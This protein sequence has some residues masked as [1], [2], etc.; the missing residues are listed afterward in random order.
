MSRMILDDLNSY[1]VAFWQANQSTL[2]QGPPFNIADT[3]TNIGN[4][5]NALNGDTDISQII[6]TDNTAISLNV[7]RLTS[8]AT[9]ISKLVNQDSSPVQLTVNDTAAHIGNG[10]A[11]IGTNPLVTVVK[12]SD[13]S[14]VTVTASQF[15]SNL[16]VV[17]EL[18]N[19]N[20]TAAQIIVKDTAV[21]IASALD[22]IETYVVHITTASAFVS[23]IV[24]S[25]SFALTLTAAQVANDGDALAIV[26]NNNG[27]PV[28]FKVADTAANITS[29]LDALQANGQIT[30]ITDTD[31][32]AITV[33]VAQITADATALG[34][35]V[36]A[37][38][39]P[40]T[41]IVNDTAAH[42]QAA[43]NGLSGNSEITKIVV[44]DS[45]T[46]EVTITVAQSISDSQALSHLYQA[47]GT[48][49][50]H[51][52]VS[53]TSANISASFDALNGNTHVDKIVITDSATPLA[54]NAVQVATDTTA[55]G[56]IQGSYSIHVTDTAL[57]V[58]A[59]LNAL[60][61]NGHVTQIVVSDN[62]EITVSVAQLSSDATVI[63]E[64]QNANASTV[65]VIVA[66]TAAAI[67][68]ALNALNGNAL[69]NK[70]VVSDSATHEVTITANMATN[71]TTALNELF[72]ADGT[73]PATVAVFDSAANIGSHL[74]ALNG[75]SHV[76]KVI[77]SDSATNEVTMNVARSQSDTTL[78]N[79]LFNANGTT[80]A[81]IAVNDTAAH[82]AG[83]FDS[84]AGNTHVNKII[85]S[86]SAT[87]E[88]TITAAQA[89]S[90]T[91]AL[92]E[93]FQ[94]NGT[95]PAHV[96][97]SDTAANISSA[98]DALS[99]NSHVDKIIV[100]D[101]ATHEVQVSV[102]QL[103]SDAAALNE[104]F[105]ADGITA[106]HVAV[107]DT[108]A[109]I[110]AAFDALN[111]NG[112]V[113]KIIVSD[114]GA[115]EVTI[116]VAQAASDTTALNELF[117][118]GGS[119]P[120]SVAV[121]DTASAISG[122]FDA[123]NNNSHVNKIIVGNSATNEV[124]ITASQAAND[125]N[126]LGELKQADGVSAAHVAVLDTAAHISGAF[127]ALSGN[128][129]V[130]KIIVSD[131][132]GSEV[133]ITAAQAASDTTA[134]NEL[135]QANGTT[136]AHVAV[137]DTAANLS[138][139]LDALNANTHVDKILIADSNPL[140]LTAVQVAGDTTALG[141][142]FGSY[143]IHVLDS[144]SSIQSNLDAIQAN[145]H[146]TLITVSDNAEITVSVAQLSSDAT[147]IGELH[148]L[149]TSTVH[150]IVADTASAIAGAFDTLSG[151]SIVNKIVV[152]DSATHEVTITASQAANDTAALNELFQANG[153]TP[154]EVAVSDTASAITS[155][156]DALNG[157]THVDKIIVSDSA[158]HEVSVTV[159]QLTSD[160]SAL[161]ELVKADGTTPATVSVGDTAAHISA[162][163]D[164]LSGNAQVDKIVVSDSG[165]NEVSV[166]V[167]QL[168]SDA[169]AL[170]ELFK[171]DGTTP[172]TITV[173]DTASDIQTALDTLNSNTQVDHIVISDNAAL[174]L[175]A[176]QAVN[177]STAIGELSNADHS[178]VQ[179][180]VSDTAANITTYIDQL[181][182]ESN[183]SSIVISDNQPL[184]LDASQI[185]DD[186][187]GLAKLSNAD[188]SGVEINVVD[189]GA[190]ISANLDAL[191]DNNDIVSITVSDNA[192]ITVSVTQ[193][194][195]DQVVLAELQNQNGSDIVLKVKDTAFQIQTN[196]ATLN[197]NLEISQIIISNNQ[198]LTL[199]ISQLTTDAHALSIM[200]NNNASPYTLIIS[201]NAT[202][203]SSALDALNGN[204]HVTSIV[205]TNSAAIT[206]T[207]AQITSDATAL[208]KLS[209]ANASTYTLSVND[210]ATHIQAA[211]DA[212]N[213]NSHV[214]KIVVTDSA[215]AEI[216]LTVT[217]FTTDTAALAELFQAN[218]TSLAHVKVAD[219][220]ANITTAF[221][222]LSGSG[223]V[224]K[225]IVTDSATHEVQVSIAQLSSDATGLAELVKADGTTQATV[226]VVDTA[227]DITSALGSLNTAT[228]VDK[229][230]VSDSATNEVVVSSI[231]NITADATALGELYKA[232]G[233]TLATYA[234]SDTAANVTAA[235]DTLNGNARLDKI[236]VSDS[237]SNEVQVSVAQLTSDAIALAELYNSNGTTH[238]SVV[239]SDTAGA[240]Q[241]AFDGLSANSQVNKIV[242]NDSV[243]NEVTITASQLASDAHAISELYLADG[244]THAHVAVTDTAAGISANF[245]ALALQSAVDKIIVTDSATNEVTITAAQAKNDTTTLNELFKADGTTPAHVAVSD[246]AANISSNLG[247]LNGNT[248]VDKIVISDG[249]PLMLTVSQ[250]VND[251]TALGE[252]SGSYTIQVTD[253]AT[254]ITSFLNQL[255]ANPNVTLI[256]VSDNRDVTVSIAQL[257][258]DANV[259][260]EMVDANGSAA[261]L[262]ILDTAANITSNLGNLHADLVGFNVDVI[263]ISDN[264][265]ITLS[266]AQFTADGDVLGHLRNADK[267][268]V[269]L[270]VSDTAGHLATI[271]DAMQA[272]NAGHTVSQISVVEVSNNLPMTITAGQVTSDASI[273][274]EV[275]NRNGSPV[276]FKVSDTAAHISTAFNT[277][278]ADSQ[279]ASIIV[280]DNAAIGLNVS[281]LSND[282]ST[283]SKL[284]NQD[285]SPYTLNITD[286]AGNISAA[287]QML[288]NNTHVT[289]VIVSD[290]ATNEVQM[291]AFQVQH[292]GT[293]LG[294]LYNADGT[295]H[296][297]VTILDTGAHI[298]ALSVS[299]IQAL[300]GEHV[301]I[302]DASNNTLTLSVDQFNA[303]GTV[304][305]TQTDTVSL[306]GTGAQFAAE[307]DDY[308][309]SLAGKGIDKL[310]VTDHAVTFGLDQWNALGTVGITT[311]TTVTINGTAAHDVFNT[312]AGTFV[313][314]GGGG[315]DTFNAGTGH[316]DQFVYG[317]VSDSTGPNY[318]TIS[319]LNLQT[320]TFNLSVQVTGVDAAVASGT[321]DTGTHFNS[322]LAADIG[323][324]QL[325][326]HHAVLLTVTAGNLAGH[327][328]LIV[329]ANGQAG[330]QANQDI[331]I[332]VTGGQHLTGLNTGDFLFTT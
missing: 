52:K 266:Q 99:A 313:L 288:N 196:I 7:A 271:L 81:H 287:L 297:S 32:A 280:S 293:L 118:A 208:S 26:V 203:I 72:K 19:A 159:A 282:G 24:V 224:D 328:F 220:A 62:A 163:I 316:H 192:A 249:Q 150:V 216:Q 278:V 227:S 95:T 21:H 113:N 55:L 152:S 171:A 253:T 8:D 327:T 248:H 275:V 137:S 65:H 47:D 60:Q 234:V 256:T 157:N 64:L 210:T 302:I 199:S 307:S 236:V 306:S 66:D 100:S 304:A 12:I 247:S 76:D 303:L 200:I 44:S 326:A 193:L 73:T 166:S 82:I 242:V 116:T 218:G 16:N 170:A 104:L 241:A 301:N 237:G 244:V 27:N 274:A 238:A 312:G 300:A 213:G 29:H 179:L 325:A 142:I 296:A 212:L 86:D 126:A 155:A 285:A 17:S 20:S 141:E 131:S 310:T 132:V 329:D 162:A 299:A 292:D 214:A 111:G 185:T 87:Q 226:A 48:T 169:H 239:V 258:S 308:L 175:S 88:V 284:H 223:Q 58:G 320:D 272:Y 114:S 79:E 172:A 319:G 23:S 311:G 261:A 225:I 105:A 181:S 80:P 106:A 315:A 330:Y 144:A 4:A 124:T 206:L 270:T 165:A 5:L 230:I 92:S 202:N 140:V 235:L 321:L 42:I 101:S 54:L 43:F 195:S 147:V 94:A 6:I 246:T 125:T 217:Q 186:A 173:T 14:P 130:D 151:A 90:D 69:V 38:A 182:T 245:D 164:G 188:A 71:D 268:L 1:T 219:T 331:V 61:S 231:A 265:V 85:V 263:T 18:V 10:Y 204:T 136:P 28:T 49:A 207:V 201:D 251:T 22:T 34:K 123:L 211:F 127:D 298:Q 197:Q 78:Q 281:Q 53:D 112:H 158:T 259:L 154:A 264:A 67:A 190:N 109:N 41:L 269:H 267:S 128:G 77:V 314:N 160:A 107:A 322:E 51:V 9:A 102:A 129:H 209:N 257:T 176:S 33:T 68:L 31:N 145:G 191:Q 59:N 252:I 120:A 198:P 177:D 3:A 108:A 324:G 91:A 183:I 15:T 39:S 84:L 318:D 143:T 25:N 167:A 122:A 149:D 180:T 260:N 30:Q 40:L 121:S 250:V 295:T 146:V 276:T 221:D 174:T 286:S 254:H 98:L 57:H 63:G 70:L 35:V 115:N 83:G 13:N 161:G 153:T 93:L 205:D 138:A 215:T 148:N 229:I 291:T 294:E 37:N 262:K 187:A 228:Q 273:L 290:S 184:T 117:Q 133:T 45:A 134:L 2:D 323:A 189:T 277:L 168:A 110:Q 11:T 97:V 75:N 89:A 156:L 36:N 178:P 240:I 255:Q 119:L 222:G 46:N 232:D 96:A 135:F 103:T 194:S 283:L 289:K 332:D 279:I 56:E 139:A 50:A 309:A 243:T 233:T 305:L 74:D 317:S